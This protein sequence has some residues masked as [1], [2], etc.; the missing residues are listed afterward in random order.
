MQFSNSLKRLFSPDYHHLGTI[1]SGIADAFIKKIGIDSLFEQIRVACDPAWHLAYQPAKDLSSLHPVAISS[2]DSPIKAFALKGHILYV[3]DQPLSCQISPKS[4]SIGLM[5]DLYERNGELSICLSGGVDSCAMLDAALHSGVPF[6][7]YIMRLI[8]DLNYHDT[9]HALATCNARG[10]RPHWI[11]IDWLSFFRERTHLNYAIKY[12][13]AS[14]QIGI[15]IHFLKQVPHFPVMAWSAPVRYVDRSPIFEMPEEKHLSILRYA[16][17]E[18]RKIEPFFFISNANQVASFLSV[19]ECTIGRSLSSSSNYLQKVVL[20]KQSGFDIDA[21]PAKYTG[22]EILRVLFDCALNEKDVFNL[23]I[24]KRMEQLAPTRKSSN[25][26]ARKFESRTIAKGTIERIELMLSEI[27]CGDLRHAKG[28]LKDHLIRVAK[29]LEK[30]GCKPELVWAG[31]LHSLL[32][33]RY[34]PAPPRAAEIEAAILLNFG[35]K[36]LKLISRFKNLDRPE[37]FNYIS[38]INDFGGEDLDLLHL[39]LANAI[40]H[41]YRPIEHE[42]FFLKFLNYLPQMDS[43]E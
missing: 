26:A 17:I 12:N 41:P 18:S 31:G 35:H 29:K 2:L 5:R 6:Q 37:F 7:V 19:A 21:R 23:K 14:P 43:W 3:S 28:S 36:T 1:G 42:K 22:F 16:L 40:D 25:F 8:G 20:Y 38:S 10:I 32:G 15:Y 11:D 4:V 30:W 33:T 34:F 24:R 13:C 9:Q 39:L 27:N